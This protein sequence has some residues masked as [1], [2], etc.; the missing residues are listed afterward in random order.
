M[1]A[2]IVRSDF[3]GGGD[4]AGKGDPWN[5]LIMEVVQLLT[6]EGARRVENIAIS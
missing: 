6:R 2:V 1:P 3:H 4:Q 5:R